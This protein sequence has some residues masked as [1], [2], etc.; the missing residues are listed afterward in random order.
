MSEEKLFDV[1]GVQSQWE[2][3][4]G[5][6]DMKLYSYEPRTIRNMSVP[7]S[8]V[9]IVLLIGSI[10]GLAYSEWMGITGDYKNDKLNTWLGLVCFVLMFG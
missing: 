3:P 1:N 5:A 10:A 7:G 4:V 9:W 2:T 8:L 6:Q